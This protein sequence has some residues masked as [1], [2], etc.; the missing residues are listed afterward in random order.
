MS[1]GTACAQV[2]PEEGME[3]PAEPY[4]T[5]I[6]DDWESFELL[7]NEWNN[8]LHSSRADII[9]LTWEW[10]R[11]WVSIVGASVKPLAVIVRNSRAELVG[12]A[13][14]YTSEY[15]LLRAIRYR[16]L[17]LMADYASGAECLDWI[18]Q[19][20]L[21][22]RIYPLIAT[23]LADSTDRWDCI[24]MPYIP[25]WTGASDRIGRAC[26][27][28]GFSCRE[29]VAEFGC[30]EL[31]ESYQVFF[32][33]LPSKRRTELRRHQKA[34]LNGGSADITCCRDAADVDRYLD[35][36]LTL[37]AKRWQ[38]RGDNGSFQ[39]KP[40]EA[41]FYRKFMPIAFNNGW[42]RFYG[43]SS[44]GDFKAV[45]VGYAYGGSF[46]QL[47]EGFDPDYSV[48]TGNVLRAKVF[49]DCFAEGIRTYDFLGEMS[50]HKKKW[51]AKVRFG[52]HFF[53]GNRNVRSRMLFLREIWPTGRYLR[54]S[55]LPTTSGHLS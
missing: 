10:V 15:R 33:S 53:V 14:F 41:A 54:P 16:V 47:Q 31:P 6:I 12:V 9:F 1:G 21:E 29:R 36:L 49:E 42:L 34:A 4:R 23:A 8:L 48:G 50:E 46:Y 38:R 44:G 39:R 43:L 22:D 55:L 35:A 51:L 32:Q 20:G 7:A 45:Q 26:R 37:H 17:R 5:E 27:D 28:Q 30:T 18:V 40:A 25:D 24:W 11:T 13:P 52:R 3:V 2:R 19:R